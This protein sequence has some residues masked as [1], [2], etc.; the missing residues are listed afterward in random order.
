MQDMRFSWES[1][2]PASCGFLA[3]LMKIMAFSGRHDKICQFSLEGEEGS[4]DLRKPN[5]AS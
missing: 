5:K 3:W 2:L 1:L 4:L